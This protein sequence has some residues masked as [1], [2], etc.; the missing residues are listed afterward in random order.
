MTYHG[1][2]HH[3]GNQRTSSY[4]GYRSTFTSCEIRS[5]PRWEITPTAR[6]KIHTFSAGFLQPV[7]HL[8]NL[9]GSAPT[10]QVSSKPPRI[11]KGIKMSECANQWRKYPFRR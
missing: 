10:S 1:T 9:A 3:P 6:E 8:N 4:H 11:F 7:S 5:N 2:Y